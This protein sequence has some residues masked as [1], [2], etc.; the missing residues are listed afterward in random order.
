MR[1]ARGPKKRTIE[2]RTRREREREE[3][4][5]RAESRDD[6]PFP[7][8]KN[9]MGLKA[10]FLGAQT[11]YSRS[12]DLG[13][14]ALAFAEQFRR[15]FFCTRFP[16]SSDVVLVVHVGLTS[17]CD[18]RMQELAP[19]PVEKIGHNGCEREFFELDFLIGYGHTFDTFH[20]QFKKTIVVVKSHIF[21][22]GLGATMLVIVRVAVYVWS[23]NGRV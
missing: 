2:M 5:E 4:R 6:S 11:L 7:P 14:I 16:A 15:E 21:Y 18:V 20:S 3:E 13:R 9:R 12:D 17:G 1:S 19:P 23:A 22:S 10:S 8:Q